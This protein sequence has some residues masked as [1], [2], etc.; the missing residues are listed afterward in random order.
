MAIIYTDQDIRQNVWDEISHD[1]RIDPTDITVRVVDGVV[2]LE[3][4]VPSYSQKLTAAEDARRIKGVIDV[5]NNLKVRP[6]G[7]WSD[8]EIRD[9]VRFNIDFDSRITDPTKIHVSVHNGVV[10]LSGAVPS[11]G[12]RQAAENDAWA[13][14]GVIDV[15]D[16]LVVE[17]PTR[18]SDDEIRADVRRAMDTDPDI[19]AARVT[20]DV[21]D[22][23]VYLRGTVPTYYQIGK[24]A[25]DAWSVPGVR[26]VVNELTV[27]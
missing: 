24:A 8:D 12:Q 21:V 14:P 6:T 23:T 19:N 20:V 4:S 10:T 15:I 25:D 18:R 22:G 26:N 27:D 5:V 2:Y 11:Y 7:T 9:T 3:G 16:D 17:P 1:V 13:A